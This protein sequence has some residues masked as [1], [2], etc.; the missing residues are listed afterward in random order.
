MH[1]IVYI[2]VHFNG[3][4]LNSCCPPAHQILPQFA[5]LNQRP[6]AHVVGRC[7]A[8]GRVT[9]RSYTVALFYHDYLINL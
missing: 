7:C 4:Y 3:T 1:V 2:I 5:A 9:L 6:G 8:I